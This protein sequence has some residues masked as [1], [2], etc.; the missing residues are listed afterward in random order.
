[1]TTISA[2][3]PPIW[4]AASSVAKPIP[5]SNSSTTFRRPAEPFSGD[6]KSGDGG[7]PLLAESILPLYYDLNSPT[8]Q[9]NLNLTE[10]GKLASIARFRLRPGDDVSCLNLYQPR[11]PR[12]LA[13][14]PDFIRA[15]RFAF[16]S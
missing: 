9:E 7:Y 1:M 2:P 16:Q 12:I 3:C 8:G 6:R 14:T 10:L 11:N 15:G 4:I 5:P 13:P